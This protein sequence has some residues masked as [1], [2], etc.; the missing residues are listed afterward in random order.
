MFMLFFLCATTAAAEE[1]VIGIMASNG[2]VNCHG[3]EGRGGA[4]GT[5][6]S[7]Q[8]RS[9]EFLRTAMQAYK[10]NVSH[11]TVMNRVMKDMDDRKIEVLAEY[12]SGIK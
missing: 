10:H 9:K 5:I 11:G 4:I 12:F 6:P 8:G 7:L 1:N 3:Y 2:C